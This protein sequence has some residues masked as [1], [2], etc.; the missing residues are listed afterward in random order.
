MCIILMAC[1]TQL[2]DIGDD[3]VKD[4]TVDWK[5]GILLIKLVTLLIHAND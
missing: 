3:L 5:D 1:L 2:D 4:L